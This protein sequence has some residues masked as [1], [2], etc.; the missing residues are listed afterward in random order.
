MIS[1]PQ[2]GR[3][4]LFACLI[5]DHDSVAAILFIELASFMGN[6]AA[7]DK[8]D[9][10]R[11]C[12][13]D[14]TVDVIP[15]LSIVGEGADQF[16]AGS[17]EHVAETFRAVSV[18]VAAFDFCQAEIIHFF[19]SEGNIFLEVMSQAVKLESKRSFETWTVASGFS[20]TDAVVQPDIH[21][22]SFPSVRFVQDIEIAVP[23]EIGQLAFVKPV[24]SGEQR[25]A[26]IA[27]AI[28]VEDP[29]LSFG[30]SES[31]RFSVH[32]AIS[33]AKISK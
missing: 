31:G 29:S 9:T 21:A 15:K 17:V 24:S 27:F 2:A 12:V 18:I 3:L 26:E 11:L 30:L 10:K 32:L 4:E 6:P 8:L 1:Q 33:A 19:D 28:P 5:E 14:D 22:R 25:F 7:K 20:G 13:G 23:I 16:E